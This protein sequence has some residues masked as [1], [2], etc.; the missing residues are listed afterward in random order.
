MRSK[1]VQVEDE[2][3]MQAGDEMNFRTHTHTRSR[4]S[5]YINIKIYVFSVFASHLQI[6]NSQSF[7]KQFNLCVGVANVYNTVEVCK[8]YAVVVLL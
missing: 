2:D 3:D 8:M 4:E 7:R 6:I 1:D 5:E